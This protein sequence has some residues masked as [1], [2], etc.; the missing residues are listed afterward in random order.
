[1]KYGDYL[2]FL[3]LAAIWGASFLFMRVASPVLGAVNTAFLRVLLGCVGLALWLWLAGVRLEFRRQLK[4]CLLLGVVNSGL[5]FLMYC[6]AARAL[7]AGYSAILNATTPLLGCL[8]GWAFFHEALTARKIAGTLLGLAGVAVMT[9]AGYGGPLAQLL[10]GVAACLT[11]TACYALAGFLT[12][13]WI[14]DRGGL[15]ARLVAVGSQLGATLFLLPFFG[16]SAAVAPVSGELSGAVIVSVIALGAGCT[17]LAYVLYFRLIAD[18]GPLKSMSVT[19]LI[20]PFGLLWGWLGLGE[21]LSPN[22]L[23][24]GGMIIAAV[25]LMLYAGAERRTA[26]RR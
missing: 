23:L 2:R 12:K 4:A 7:P 24:G 18:I 13:R 9:A 26:P 22:A 17:A 8:L 14:A 15:D 25:W 5:P 20:P 11:A 10:P 3:A 21:P 1:M 16:Y 19:L 6:L